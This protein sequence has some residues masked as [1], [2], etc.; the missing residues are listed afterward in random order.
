MRIERRTRARAVLL[1]AA[2]LTVAAG[3][4]AVEDPDPDFTL[5]NTVQ[6]GPFH[7]APFFIVK[8]FG[9][10][11]NV[12]LG[13]SRRFGD[14]TV[15]LGPGARAVVPFGRR[16]ALAVWDEIDYA[17]FARES[18]LNH[19]NNSLKTKLHVYLREVT[20]FADGQQDSFRER[21]NTEIDFRIRTTT[22]QGRLG[23]SWHPSTRSRFDLYGAR[24]GFAYHA[25]KPEVAGG[26]E[27]GSPGLGGDIADTLQREETALGLDSRLRIRPR[28]TLLIE[29]RAGRIDFRQTFPNRDSSSSSIVGGLEF[30][31]TG[32]VR[33]FVKLGYKKL[34][35]DRRSLDS[36]LRPYEGFSGMI[37]DA[38]VSARL[39]GRGE[40]RAAYQRN[41]GFSVLGNN[42][43][44]L[45]D[46]RAAAYEHY[47]NSRIS[48]EAGRKLEKVKLPVMIDSKIR[49]DHL[50][51]D[52]VAVRY[53]FGPSL[54]I[55][56]AAARWR[57][58][59]TFDFDDTARTTISTL[60]EYTP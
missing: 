12:R 27:V 52:T 38:S 20:L 23:L 42:L 3:A 24:T 57:R 32:S 14:Y 37:A 17:V 41:T 5:D 58:D 22:T 13:A 19:V 49:L 1:A 2:L 55:G 40:I 26:G 6:A 36:S 15:T 16:A 34:D 7:L 51:T 44:Y 21:P 39:L 25:G 9:Y 47:F 43:Y 59:S 53:R 33:G 8:D 48:V 45:Q 50:T 18:D 35:P 28:T 46:L 54:R 31:P 60:L 4:M 29:A 30:D 11:D 56:L 10:D